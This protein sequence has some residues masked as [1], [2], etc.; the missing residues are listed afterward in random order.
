[1]T[2]LLD[3]LMKLRPTAGEA[4]ARSESEAQLRA[5]F[6]TIVDAIVVIDGEGRIL[7]FNPAAE[8]IFG[9]AAEEVMGQN[10]KILMPEPDSRQH[11]QYLKNYFQTGKPQIIGKGREV[12][13]L[14]KDGARVPLELAVSEFTF[15]GRRL[16]TGI[17]RDITERKRAEEL[18]REAKSEAESANRAKSTFL[19][20]MSHELRTPLNAIIGYSELLHEEADERGD[21]PL[22]QDLGRISVAARHLL[23]LINEV[24]DLS[25]IEAGR[26]KLDI[27]RIDVGD[28]LREVGETVR[29]LAA[30][31]GNE[32]KIEYPADV[33]MIETDPT[34]L[35]QVLI[36]LL[37][38]AVKFTHDGEISVGAK[39]SADRIYFSV[40]DSGIGMT[41]EQLDR[42]FEEFAQASD[43]T[44]KTYGGTG[45]GLAISRKF[46]RMLG[47]DISAEST[48][49]KG[50]RFIVALPLNAKA[51]AG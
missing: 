42:V 9:Y 33:G 36:N 39:R 37:A 49:E 2:G 3:R 11:D 4:P 40:I 6:R 14:H 24:L 29:P 10:V 5:I 22:L 51:E 32:M 45:L 43:S 13:G 35:R 50:S 38:N 23:T 16:F 21:Q 27:S 26:V 25:R 30:R 34:K 8:R 18:L 48:P 12:V 15:D 17:L 1:M 41:E 19:A 44:Q 7:D 28:L 31:N 47:G 46:C 20:N